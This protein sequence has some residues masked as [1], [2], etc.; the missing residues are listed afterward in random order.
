MRSAAAPLALALVVASMGVAC[1]AV[2][3]RT[4]VPGGVAYRVLLPPEPAARPWPVVVF[5]HDYFGDD[6]IL[7]RQGVA[8]ELSARMRAGAVRPFVLVAPGGD[9]GWWADAVD[10]RHLYETWVA[11]GLR[12]DVMTRFP[13]RRDGGGWAVA[14]ISMGGQGAL[15]LALRRPGA[16]GAAGALSG[17]LVPLDRAFVDG[18]A[19]PLRGPLRRVFGRGPADDRTAQNDVWRLLAAW[20]REAARP[21]FVLRAGEQDKYHLDAATRELA[22]RARRDGFPVRLTLEPGTHAWSYWHRVAADWLCEVVE[23][24]PR[25]AQADDRMLR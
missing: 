23:A 11:D 2:P 12:R 8:A 10:G 17:A 24:M 9:H 14:G 3:P 20:P 4:R 16:F 6:G 13:V 1:G 19:W 21:A 15:R 22:A 7:W 5:L 18:A 25:D